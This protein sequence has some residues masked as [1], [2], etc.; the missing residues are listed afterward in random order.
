MPQEGATWYLAANFIATTLMKH[1]RQ[2]ILTSPPLSMS[3]AEPFK[4]VIGA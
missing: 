1:G 3:V 2:L 4:S